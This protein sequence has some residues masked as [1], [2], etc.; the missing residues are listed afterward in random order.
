M[1]PPINTTGPLGEDSRTL[2]IRIPKS[3]L[4]WG[5]RGIPA[6][7]ARLCIAFGAGETDNRSC[8][9]GSKPSSRISRFVWC[10]NHQAAFVM[11]ISR[12]SLVL[13][14]PAC[15]S[16]TIITKRLR[17]FDGLTMWR[18]DRIQPVFQRWS[19]RLRTGCPRLV[20][21]FSYFH[22]IYK[23]NKALDWPDG[24]GPHRQYPQA[25]RCKG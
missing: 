12:P 5:S 18:P 9:R 22:Q 15:G 25:H 20:D 4:I 11:P 8:H 24:G 23:P 10:R 21:Y 1:S 2:R 7:H 17:I 16:L 6:V 14:R 3:P 13:T 19:N